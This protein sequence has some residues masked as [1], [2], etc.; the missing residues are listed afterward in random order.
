MDIIIS[1]TSNLEGYEILEYKDIVYEEVIFA[2]K[3][4]S[5][6]KNVVGDYVSAVGS[7]FS[8]QELS[9][10]TNAI[11]QAKDYVIKKLK[12]RASSIGAN[13]IVGIDFETS[14]GSASTSIRVSVN[15]TA[16]LVQ[17]AFEPEKEERRKQYAEQLRKEEVERQKT[18]DEANAAVAEKLERERKEKEQQM[19][20]EK[21]KIIIDFIKGLLSKSS[22]EDAVKHQSLFFNTSSLAYLKE[23]V[24]NVET[25]T[26]FEVYKTELKNILQ[27]YE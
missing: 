8:D 3:L 22:L 2:Q 14:Y 1:T 13:A 12:A 6:L 21:N 19:F 20:Q 11:L 5:Q 7:I 25:F 10:S 24:P 4:T 18:R 16:V 15:G 9:G 26:D 27:N 17:K 23:I